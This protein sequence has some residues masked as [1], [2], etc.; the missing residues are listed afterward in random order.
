M[1]P[2]LPNEVVGG[3]GE[4]RQHSRTGLT[5]ICAAGG[6][7]A[8]A[9]TWLLAGTTLDPAPVKLLTW[10][11]LSASRSPS[12]TG[13]MMRSLR[14]V[15]HTSAERMTLCGRALSRAAVRRGFTRSGCGRR[16]MRL[17]VSSVTPGWLSARF[18][19][20]S[21]GWAPQPR[22]GRRQFSIAAYCWR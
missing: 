6:A 7:A 21:F 2:R 14:D 19:L 22:Y 4:E 18:G 8:S 12:S 5:T 17:I 20:G 1:L 9:M 15:D 16:S 13:A 10:H 3:D 11:S